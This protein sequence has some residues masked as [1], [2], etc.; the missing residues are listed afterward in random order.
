MTNNKV[1]IDYTKCQYNTF[2]GGGSQRTICSLD[3]K[4]CDCLRDKDCYYK[5]L[6]R[7]TQESEKLKS[8]LDLSKQ[9][10]DS[11]LEYFNIAQYNWLEDQNE[12]IEE[13]KSKIEKLKLYKT[14]YKAKHGDIR[15]LLDRYKSALEE[16]EKTVQENCGYIEKDC[17][18]KNILRI[19][20][21]AKEQE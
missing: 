17:N 15:N 10:T 21:K 19:I 5:Q 1:I 16:I 13:I 12:I 2:D 8:D 9:L 18:Y 7:K 3:N 6:A 11:I 4:Y 14:W 20:N